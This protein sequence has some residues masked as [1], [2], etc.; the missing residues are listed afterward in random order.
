MRVARF[1][2]AM[3]LVFA[4]AA[5]LSSVVDKAGCQGPEQGRT[6]PYI[7][8]EGVPLL[9]NSRVQLSQVGTN[10]TGFLRCH[11]DLTDTCCNNGS[12]SGRWVAVDRSGDF[13]QQRLVQG[14]VDLHS[15]D[16]FSDGNFRCEIDT[17]VS[18]ARGGPRDIVY[19]SVIQGGMCMF[20]RRKS[21]C[22]FSN[23][24]VLSSLIFHSRQLRSQFL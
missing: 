3:S 4:I 12:H 17:A 20:E 19:V 2:G 18:I 14:G 23:R 8:F 7:S 1:R 6:A 9:N 15:V 16:A 11:T 13:Y 21:T 24:C 22:A 10:S 5:V